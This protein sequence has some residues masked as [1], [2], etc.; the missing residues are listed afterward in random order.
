MFRKQ[1]VKQS[2]QNNN[3]VEENIEGDNRE[4]DMYIQKKE[5]QDSLMLYVR[6]TCSVRANVTSIK[7]VSASLP[8]LHSGM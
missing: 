5:K 7:V 4:Y 2:K 1:E 8:K 3:K 6:P